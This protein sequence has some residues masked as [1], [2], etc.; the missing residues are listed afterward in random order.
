MESTTKLKVAEQGKDQAQKSSLTLREQ[1]KA[2]PFGT[3]KSLRTN[4][5]VIPDESGWQR[6]WKG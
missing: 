5:T 2:G 3:V 6:Y 4:P 1:Q